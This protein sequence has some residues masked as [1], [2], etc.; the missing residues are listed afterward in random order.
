MGTLRCG[1]AA[2]DVGQEFRFIQRLDEI[3]G[4]ATPRVEPD[5]RVVNRIQE[6]GGCSRMVALAPN[7]QVQA[8]ERAQTDVSNKQFGRILG[9]GSDRGLEIGR[10]SDLVPAALQEADD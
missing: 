3:R 5:N 9:E 7:D 6:N 8:V 1:N 10:E 4:P 2:R